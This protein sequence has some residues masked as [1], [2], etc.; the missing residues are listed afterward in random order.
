MLLDNIKITSRTIA[1]GIKFEGKQ[2]FTGKYVHP[3]K[4]KYLFI[5]SPSNKPKNKQLRQ[6]AGDIST[7]HRLAL[8][9]GK[10]LIQL[11]LL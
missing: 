8:P 2:K 5:H 9:L 3:Q 7:M 1:P 10:L 4:F 6:M 11:E